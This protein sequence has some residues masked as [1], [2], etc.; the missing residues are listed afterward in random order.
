LRRSYART[1][2]SSCS[3]ARWIANALRTSAYI[4]PGRPPSSP[5]N[6]P[7]QPASWSGVTRCSA[8]SPESASTASVTVLAA[9]STPVMS[10]S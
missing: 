1:I 6:R 8:S 10:P 9:R 7:V 4:L 5:K 3:R 2:G